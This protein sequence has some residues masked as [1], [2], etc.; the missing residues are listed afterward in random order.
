[1]R[2]IGLPLRRS[3]VG[4]NGE[5]L[6]AAGQIPQDVSFT[7]NAKFFG[8]LRIAVCFVAI[9]IGFKY[10]LTWNRPLAPFFALWC[11]FTI[12]SGV[13]YFRARRD[14]VG[15]VYD[16]LYWLDTA[17]FLGFASLTGRQESYFLL[18]LPIPVLFISL[19]SGFRAGMLVAGGAA[20]VGLAMGIEHGGLANNGHI[21]NILLPP[22]VVLGVSY[23]I[24]TLGHAN[25]LR[26]RR[27]A[28]LRE[29]PALFNPR[30]GIEQTFDRIVRYVAR[31]YRVDKFA[32]VVAEADGSLRLYRANLPDQM[33]RVSDSLTAELCDVLLGFATTE[34]IIY[35]GARGLRP[36]E[37]HDLAN[38]NAVS[39]DRRLAEAKAVA[40]RLDC[41]EFSCVQFNLYRGGSV[42]LFVCSNEHSFANGDLLLM[43]QLAEQIAPRIENLQLL[44]R[45]ASEV[46]EHER[47]KISRDIHDS[48]IQ[49]YIGLKFALEALGRKAAADNPLAKDIERLAEMT[50]REISELRR[51]VK[52]LRG[53]GDPGDA[54]LVPALRRQAARFGE[55]YGINVAIEAASELQVGDGLADQVFHM[56]SEALSNV[57]RHTTAAVAR[58]SLS[59][60]TQ[61]FT[62]QVANPGDADVS[63]KIFTP[64][65]IAERATTLG[66][67]CRVEAG[68]DRG[69]VVIVEV[70]MRSY[71]DA[72]HAD[73][74]HQTDKR[75]S[76]GRP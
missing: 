46:A 49:P 2:L 64:R 21:A 38:T 4:R 14:C 54:A 30:L 67:T 72:S 73:E 15:K 65:S 50:Q 26:N 55:L 43:H 40:N 11:L 9:A 29:I 32:L 57:R 56:V 13:L 18:L 60:D 59:C 39:R 6:G 23:A 66:G 63:A 31:L 62:L 48:A 27:I 24:A 74:R 16:I 70:P 71:E 20:G 41:V 22:I 1:M 28:S 37:I 58:V 36:A 5:S 17:W 12:Y 51:Y 44:D 68:F 47:Q 75:V 7:A 25:R 8:F 33:Y 45:L 3:G 34:L 52:G 35:R 10:C 19:R 53:Q 61:M 69:T 42:R 76:G